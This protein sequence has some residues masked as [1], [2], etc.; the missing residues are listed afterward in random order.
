MSNI[1]QTPHGDSV[2]LDGYLV[3]FKK[4]VNCICY[5]HESLFKILV[6]DSLINSGETNKK[7]SVNKWLTSSKNHRMVQ[8]VELED[9]IFARLNDAPTS[10]RSKKLALNIKEKEKVQI[11]VNFPGVFEARTSKDQNGKE[12]FLPR[13]YLSNSEKLEYAKNIL[14]CK[15]GV[16]LESIALTENDNRTVHFRK[17]GKSISLLSYEVRV[18]ASVKDIKLFKNAFYN[19]LGKRKTWG[20]G[21]LRVEKLPSVDNT[22]TKSV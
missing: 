17:R 9:Y 18:I 11:V 3:A 19:G 13:K 1:E 8:F 15:G 14:E 16:L 10:L 6:Q 21:M 5:A 20:F 2:L 12:I 7:R 4:K 22:E